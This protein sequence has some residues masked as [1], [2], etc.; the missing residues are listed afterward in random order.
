VSCGSWSKLHWRGV[1]LPS[2]G[3]PS[4]SGAVVLRAGPL[5]GCGAERGVC[6]VGLEEGAVDVV[7]EGGCGWVRGWALVGV[8][9][10]G[11]ELFEQGGVERLS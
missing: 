2:S 5:L 6:E 11:L 8:V 1:C 7:C 3:P 9:H 4:R 10:D